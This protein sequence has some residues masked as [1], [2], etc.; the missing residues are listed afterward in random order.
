MPPFGDHVVT[1]T[2]TVPPE[3]SE[4]S[5]LGHQRYREIAAVTGVAILG[6]L[7]ISQLRPGLT[8]QL[9]HLGIPA[10]FQAPVIN[11]IET[12]QIPQTTPPTPA[13]A[14]SSRR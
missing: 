9:S 3:R 7:V 14:R 12:G 6:S 1:P 5:R 8:V 4:V 10:Q 2:L 13:T 11:P